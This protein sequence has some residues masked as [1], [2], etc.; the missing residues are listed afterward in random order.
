MENN[1][2]GLRLKEL[3]KFR[4]LTASDLAKSLGVALG[5]VFQYE[6]GSTLPRKDNVER[7]ASILGVN[8]N[9]FYEDKK[10]DQYIISREFSLPKG[11]LNK[12]GGLPSE[13]QAS[14][15]KMIDELVN[16]VQG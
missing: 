15:I 6:N 8:Q 9:Y 16:V 11:L 1:F 3:R 12:I 13:K 5:T 7:M 4:G 2:N 14:L 10:I